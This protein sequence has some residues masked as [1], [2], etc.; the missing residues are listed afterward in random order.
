MSLMLQPHNLVHNICMSGVSDY[1]ILVNFANI[2]LKIFILYYY[3]QYH[4]SHFM[5]CLD[6]NFSHFM[7]ACNIYMI[8]DYWESIITLIVYHSA[9]Y[10]I[11]R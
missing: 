9:R 2:R 8:S 1:C 10:R 3:L 11:C 6:P 5:Q 4:F 7:I